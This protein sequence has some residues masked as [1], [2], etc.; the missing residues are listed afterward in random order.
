MPCCISVHRVIE[1]IT[2]HSAQT[3]QYSLFQRRRQS[4]DFSFQIWR[5]FQDHLF[6]SS[7]NRN[8]LFVFS[9]VSIFYKSTCFW[10]CGCVAH[11]GSST[12]GKTGPAN[13]TTRGV[14]VACQSYLKGLKLARHRPATASQFHDL[15]IYWHSGGISLSSGCRFVIIKRIYDFHHSAFLDPK[16]NGALELWLHR[17]FDSLLTP[18]LGPIIS[19]AYKING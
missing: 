10:P 2:P 5:L 1:D 6:K 13:S 12:F 19:T 3:S 15:N 14:R 4:D 11:G 17:S 8:H 7:C 18:T 9:K 16:Q